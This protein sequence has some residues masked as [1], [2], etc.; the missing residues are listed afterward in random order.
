M[1]GTRHTNLR[2][3]G[4]VSM[5]AWKEKHSVRKGRRKWIRSEWNGNSERWEEELLEP[6]IYTTGKMVRPLTELER[7]E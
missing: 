5:T 7:K 6:P 1:L 3:M 4:L 2:L